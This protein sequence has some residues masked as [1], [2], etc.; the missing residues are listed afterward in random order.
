MRIAIFSDNF[1]PELS[2][3][4]ETITTIGASFAKR[5]HEV[6]YFVPSYSDENY[7]IVNRDRAFAMGPNVS[8]FR[9]PAMNVKNGNRQ[10][11]LVFPIG[12]SFASLKKFDPDIIHFHLFGGTSIEAIMMA[13]LLK[14]PLVGTNH[15]PILR[16]IHYSPIRTEW[17]KRFALHYDSWLYNHCDFVSSPAQVIFDDMPYFDRTIPHYPVSNPIDTERFHPVASKLAIKKK[18]G[19]PHFTLLFVNK[20]SVEKRADLA[21]QAVAKL[22]SKIPDLTLVFAGEGP[23][24]RKMEDLAR[25]LGISQRVKFLGFVQPDKELP[26]LYQASD[27]FVIMSEVETQSIAAM[28]ALSSGIP[29]LAANAYGLKEYITSSEGFLIEPGNDQALAEDILLLHDHPG[30]RK[31]MG[32]DGRQSVAKFSIEHIT[33]LWEEIYRT[34]IWQYNKKHAN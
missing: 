27:A 6:A 22:A 25:S 4:T 32:Q 21:I 7:R 10:G 13:K 11:R 12:T 17:F 15:T 3:I 29:V 2:G 16:Y 28:Q 24:Q 19:L 5:G 26:E 30:L 23:Y 31:K 14:K 34:T 9:M 33:D 18:M 20:I 8:I 1:Y